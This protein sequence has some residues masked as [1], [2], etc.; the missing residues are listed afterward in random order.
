M[1]P[2]NNLAFDEHVRVRKQ[3]EIHPSTTFGEENNGGQ[4]HR[5]G[6][7]GASHGGGHGRVFLSD[8]E[9]LTSEKKHERPGEYGGRWLEGA[10]AGAD[11]RLTNNGWG[12]WGQ[13][14][15]REHDETCYARDEAVLP[16]RI[17]K[18]TRGCGK[19][20]IR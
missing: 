17:R 20:K 9:A 2:R 16:V 13:D 14:G 6:E 19:I 4:L 18:N 15:E 8:V 5:W 1:P 3:T 7:P 11:P 12:E 10:P